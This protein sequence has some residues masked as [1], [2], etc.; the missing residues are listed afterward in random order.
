M[1][2][3]V[4]SV[5]R[6]AASSRSRFRVSGSTSANTGVPPASTTHSAVAKKLK[7][8]TITS[9]PGA[10]S[11]AR[12]AST[13]ASVPLATP[14][15]PAAPSQLAKAFSK[16]RTSGPRTKAVSARTPRQRSST[17]PAIESRARDRLK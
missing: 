13:R 14:T 3:A 17:A 16:A 4:R 1:T 11:S 12:R 7:A 8:G 2:P 6:P 5:T 15:Q 10:R 9:S